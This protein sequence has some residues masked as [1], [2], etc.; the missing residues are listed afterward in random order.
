MVYHSK[1]IQH[2]ESYFSK[3]MMITCC[4]CFGVD[5]WMHWLNV[6][7]CWLV[8]LKPAK[9]HF[10]YSNVTREVEALAWQKKEKKRAYS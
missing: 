6:P 1:F 7:F 9:A 8:T 5:A 2:K 3:G 4:V 10:R